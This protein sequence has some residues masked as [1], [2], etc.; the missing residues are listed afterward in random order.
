MVMNPAEATVVLVA[1]C[2]VVLTVFVVMSEP[3]H[4]T[5]SEI[6]SAGGKE[7]REAVDAV[8]WAWAAA[9]IVMMAVPVA[10]YFLTLHAREKGV[11]YGE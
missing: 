2:F 10:W 3:L 6:R 9:G 1:V 4:L 11:W 8:E 7:T 5:L